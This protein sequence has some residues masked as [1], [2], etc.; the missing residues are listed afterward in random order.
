M[1][2]MDA[3]RGRAD[4]SNRVFRTGKFNLPLKKD[5]RGNYKLKPGWRIMVNM[6]SDTFLDEAQPWMDEFWAIIRKRPDLIFW[7]LTKRP[8]NIP[9]MLPPDWGTGYPNVCLNITAE[10]QEMLD[11]RWRLFRNVPAEHKGLCC[12]PLLGPVDLEPVLRSGQIECVSAGGENYENPRPC[13]FEWFRDMA[14]QCRTF[15]VRFCMYE[16]GTWIERDGM[17]E[18]WPLK[19]D[20]GAVSYFSGLSYKGVEPVYDL[21][22]PKTGDALDPADLPPKLYNLK[23]CAFCANRMLC[24]GCLSCGKCGSV[25]LGDLNA[26]WLHEDKILKYGPAPAAAF[27]GKPGCPAAVGQAELYDT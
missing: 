14:I 10:N 16:S 1:Y 27:S 24:N 2:F 23:H 20:Q 26:L 13:R 25:L 7:I 12:A 15:G 21:R 22:D 19:A 8:E 5:R 6:T 4:W 9:H 11:R 3:N 17:M 18:C